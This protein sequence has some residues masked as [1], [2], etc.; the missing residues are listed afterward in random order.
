MF[1]DTK[2]CDISSPELKPTPLCTLSTETVDDHTWG[3][4][5]GKTIPFASLLRCAEALTSELGANAKLHQDEPSQKTEEKKK[6]EEEEEEP[7]SIIIME[8]DKSDYTTGWPNG[9]KGEDDWVDEVEGCKWL[10][11]QYPRE[12]L[13]VLGLASFS[14]RAFGLILLRDDHHHACSELR[15]PGNRAYWRRLGYCEWWMTN[16]L[17]DL[18]MRPGSSFAPGVIDALEKKYG[19]CLRAKSDDWTEGEGLFG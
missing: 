15:G 9:W 10:A 4:F 13:I 7:I 12:D 5:Q 17:D 8:L 16:T 2:D 1:D 11:D 18:E 3:H 19:P 14:I 6:E